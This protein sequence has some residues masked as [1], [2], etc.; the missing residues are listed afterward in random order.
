MRQVELIGV[1]KS[2]G[3]GPPA[4]ARSDFSVEKGEFFSLLGPS[5]C[6]K[7]TT[8][9]MIAGFV[10]P[11]SGTIRLGGEDVTAL[12]PERRA[13]GIVF[14]NYAI[15]PHM[16]VAQN[17]GY[18]LKLRKHDKA[19]IAAA[20]GRALEQVG[21]VGYENRSPSQLSG[22]E[23]QRVALARVIVLEPRL[24]LLDE[25]LSALDKRLRDEMRVWLKRLQ[26]ELGITTIYVTH[27]Q[28]EALSLSDRIAVMSK[29][30]VQQIGTPAE[31]YERPATRFVA[32][33]I[34]ESNLFSCRVEG[35]TGAL[36]TV[37]LDDGSKAL[38]PATEAA[39]R[40]ATLMV[41][42]E[43][44]LIGAADAANRYPATIEE[45]AYH[46][47]HLRFT[48]RLSPS[49]I[50][51][52]ERVN[53]GGGMPSLGERVTIGWQPESGVLIPDAP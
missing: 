18:G 50:V 23:Q 13:I 3:E 24:L 34:G 37:A 45:I 11:S 52:G 31:I 33:F 12:P 8:L 26:H 14:Q 16:T 53:V 20:V 22:G 15:F 35:A 2:Y 6:G 47:A 9:R 41:R 19:T 48:A 30:V 38:A 29:G 43:H 32:D 36:A 28:D 25:P 1:A 7:S 21:L 4:V 10:A 39:G 5:G 40:R 17:I 27:D 46:G 49:L 44:V 51:R 42:P